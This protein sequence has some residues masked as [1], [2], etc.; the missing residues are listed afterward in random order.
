M[1]IEINMIL[2]LNLKVLCNNVKRF[3][4]ATRILDIGIFEGKLGA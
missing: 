4:A 1:L 2:F 3:A